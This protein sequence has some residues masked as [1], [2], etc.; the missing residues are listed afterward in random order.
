MVRLRSRPFRTAI[1]HRSRR[2]CLYQHNGLSG[3][4]TLDVD[5]EFQ[6]RYANQDI[7][8]AGFTLDSS[9]LVGDFGVSIGNFQQGG[10]GMPFEFILSG[11]TQSYVFP[12]EALTGISDTS[13][14][15]FEAL[16]GISATRIV[17]FESLL[18]LSDTTQFPF[19]NMGGLSAIAVFPF[20]SIVSGITSS[21]TFPFEALIGVSATRINP[22]EAL[23][24]L[25]SLAVMPWEAQG[26]LVVSTSKTFPFE[27][28]GISTSTLVFPFESIQGGVTQTKLMAFESLLGLS[29][30]RSTRSSPSRASRQ[31]QS[32]RSN[33]SALPLHECCHSSQHLV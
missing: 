29:V 5:I 15:P 22:F 17:P 24:G 4:E 7:P 26:Q 21:Y 3:N 8:T 25:S 1:Q 12:L 18:G 11:I 6:G 33:L 20:E 27:A 28:R 9:G 14:V 23:L 32:L 16:A 31:P 30:T 10:G 13:V 19:E 2:G